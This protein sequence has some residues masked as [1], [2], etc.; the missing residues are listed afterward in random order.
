MTNTETPNNT[1]EHGYANG[2]CCDACV[3]HLADVLKVQEWLA[4]QICTKR[5]TKTA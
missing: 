3:K 5:E 2:C 1:R 4:K